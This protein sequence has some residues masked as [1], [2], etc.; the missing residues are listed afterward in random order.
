[1]HVHMAVRTHQFVHKLLLSD[2]L[3]IRVVSESFRWYPDASLPGLDRRVFEQ[4]LPTNFQCPVYLGKRAP[5]SRYVVQN[6]EIHDGIENNLG[7]RPLAAGDLEN[8]SC[9]VVDKTH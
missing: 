4:K 2:H 5:L 1:M 9:L 3:V 6:R 7:S 8:F